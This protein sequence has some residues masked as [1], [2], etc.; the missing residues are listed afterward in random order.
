MD[1]QVAPNALRDATAPRRTKNYE[2]RTSSHSSGVITNG[3]RGI[4]AGVN[5]CSNS[6]IVVGLRSGCHPQD[7]ASSPSSRSAGIPFS[8]SSEIRVS[9]CRLPVAARPAQSRAEHA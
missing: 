1:G 3:S 2:P 8:R 5:R 4:V 7:H 6:A 9:P